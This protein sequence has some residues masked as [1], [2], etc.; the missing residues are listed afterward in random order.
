MIIIR[1]VTDDFVEAKTEEEEHVLFALA[2]HAY[3]IMLGLHF[4]KLNM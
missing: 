1:R 3:S 4:F 2:D